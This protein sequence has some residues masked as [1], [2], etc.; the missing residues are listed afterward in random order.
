MRRSQARHRRQRHCLSLTHTSTLS[1]SLTLSHPHTLADA[2]DGDGPADGAAQRCLE[3]L[4]LYH[5]HTH[6]YTHTH[7]LSISHTRTHTLSPFLTNTDTHTHSHSLTQ[8]LCLSHTNTH[9]QRWLEGH[10][11]D[12][13][14]S[15]ILSP[16]HTLARTQ[17]HTGTRNTVWKAT[18]S[19]SSSLASAFC[20]ALC[21]SLA[22]TQFLSHTTAA[23]CAQQPGG[24]RGKGYDSRN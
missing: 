17:S 14:L 23:I 22:H 7:T 11:L 2:P 21:L 8:S 20:S 19:P 4:S 18:L 3:G 1:L 12:L 9:T 16:F 24:F 5:T 13:F 15:V 10:G 6:T